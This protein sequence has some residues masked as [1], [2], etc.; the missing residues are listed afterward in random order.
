[1]QAFDGCWWFLLV[2]PRSLDYTTSVVC[3][4]GCYSFSRA[5]VL[6]P[7]NLTFT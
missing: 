7:C 4:V 2:A 5:L 1:M 3:L 6:R